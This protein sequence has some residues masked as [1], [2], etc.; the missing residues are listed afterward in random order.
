MTALHRTHR[1]ALILKCFVFIY[2]LFVVNVSSFGQ[3][4]TGNFY[5]Y[6]Q[7]ESP[8]ADVKEAAFLLHVFTLNDTTYLSRYYHFKGP[9][10]RQES[11]KDSNLTIPNG[12]FCWYNKDGFLDSTGMVKEG[13]KDGS[14][15]YIVSKTETRSVDYE[16]GKKVKEEVFYYDD[17]GKLIHSDSTDIDK[18]DSTIKTAEFKNGVK[19]WLAYCER[20]LHTPERLQNVLGSGT[21][22]CTVSFLVDKQGHVSDIY[23]TRSCEWS[24][25]AEVLRLIKDSPPWKP[26]EQNSK[27]V[28]Y[29]QKQSLSYRVQ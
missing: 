13:K 9:M 24:G 23:L 4:T 10:I 29:R 1:V 15:Q 16:N 8:A 25:D 11:Y 12:R 20:N 14:W 22:T 18:K 6:K 7:D 2:F 3:K 21:H 27:P 28:L 17:H 19:G 5:I 26:A